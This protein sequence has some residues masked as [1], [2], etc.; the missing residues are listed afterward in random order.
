M[1]YKQLITDCFNEYTG[2]N[3]EVLD[4]LYD[5]QVVFEDPLTKVS[6]LDN[7]KK[8]YLHAYG[9]VSEIRFNFKK[10]HQ[11]GL[12]FTCE[13]DMELKVKPLNFGR[14]YSVRGVSV[15]TFSEQ[16]NKV[17]RHHDY[18]DIGDMVYE[19]IPGV[20]TVIK[21]IKRRLH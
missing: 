16:S 7:L 8:Y 9:S 3:T 17:I 6:G 5:S 10:I 12:V 19:R 2:P 11:S 21:A 14:R 20:G 4:R 13:W 15:I 1:D 18:L